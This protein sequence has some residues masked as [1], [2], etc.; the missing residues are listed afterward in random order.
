M[1]YVN[2]RLTV[3]QKVSVSMCLQIRIIYSKYG[4]GYSL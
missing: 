3:E 2:V 4:V 1:H